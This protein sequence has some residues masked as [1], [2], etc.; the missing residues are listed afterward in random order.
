MNEIEKYI[1]ELLKKSNKFLE[2]DY[3]LD[4]FK[5]SNFQ[6][7]NFFL[8]D[9]AL[10]LNKN[11]FIESFD[12][13]LP[14]ISQFPTILA[15]AI[16]L[17]FKNYC[18]DKTEYNI[19][20]VIQGY[21]GTRGKIIR[22]ED[23]NFIVAVPSDGSSRTLTAKQIR[24]NWIITNADLSNRKVKTKFTAYKE[25]YS[26]LFKV[27][28]FPSKFNYKSAIILEKK[29]FDDEIKNQTYT[30]IDIL[31]AIPIRWISKNGTESWNHI[32]IEPMIL[33]VPDFET[34]E[35]YV[36]EK[37]IKIESLIVIGK[38]KYKDNDLTKI[39]RYLREGD[40]PNCVILG[41]EGFEDNNSQFLKWKWTYEEFAVLENLSL[42]RIESLR[43]Q[44]SK[45]EVAINSFIDFLD[46]LETTYSINLNNIKMLR[47]FLYPLVLSKESNSRNTNQL[48]YV[49]HLMHK[50]SRECIIENLYNQNIDPGQ[51]ITNVELLIDGIF[52]TF[53]NDKFRLLDKV[54][55]DIIII[56]E[57]L[58]PNWKNEFKSKSKLLSLKE[59]FKTQNNFITTKQVLVLSLFGNGM[60]PF[61]VVRN[62]LNTKHNYK[63]LCYQEESEIL[64]NLQNR[65]FNEIIG[66]YTSS[67]REMITGLKYE[68]TPIEIKVSDLIEDLHDKSLKDKKEYNYEDT[69]Q[70]NYEIEFEEKC[71][72][73]ISDG[74]K[75]VLLLS[76]NKWTKSKVSNLI[77]KDRVRI[78]NNLSKEKLFEIAAQ[79]DTK[80]RF[81]KVDSDS[82]I[83]KEALIKYY[84]QKTH[85]N[86]FYTE[87][88]LMK[89][90]QKS[91]LTISNPIT[92]KKW[93]TKDDKERFPNS[94]N[95]L[96]A[97]KSTLNDPI[98]NENFESIKRS[99][100]FY[101]G[102]M[103]SLGRD[104]S[105][106][107][108]EYIVSGGKCIGKILSNFTKDEIEIF[109]QKAA[110]ERTIKNISITE[111]D[112]SI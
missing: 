75:N 35:E 32:P 49:Q 4:S 72:K 21:N 42:G 57:P 26:L 85:T 95:N 43:I 58:L 68:I 79:Q 86:P 65:Y 78:Y 28:S 92:I 54:D 61:D 39:K 18:D 94:A 33:C 46:S 31:K 67:N 27:E 100:R 5:I 1:F 99:K 103:I 66:E 2:E 17:F 106:D 80:G 84:N 22:K 8:I 29:E 76:N 11:L 9:K 37:G 52:G 91:G 24:K 48:D 23:D 105:D 97:I 109:I 77:Q 93:L 83:W 25:L 110:P 88:D 70:I 40:I 45:F 15:A 64:E 111:E 12:K 13:E 47:K 30:N 102:I 19:G 104:L 87:T 3:H 89:A 112:E 51:E 82:K 55:F 56:P 6:A 90:L 71:E 16:S 59:F 38:N 50:V 20:D 14:S 63:F 98:L 96:I 36:L 7:I 81:N 101:R 108:M 53:T 41:N 74:S 10:N 69:E 34:L 62:F 44:D 73:I 107:V 60:Q